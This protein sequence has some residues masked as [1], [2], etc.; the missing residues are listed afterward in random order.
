MANLRAVSDMEYYPTQPGV[1][2]FVA[3]LFDY[4]R[5]PDT[6]R[7]ID[8][9][10][11]EGDA[12]RI[13]EDSIRFE[14]EK[15]NGTRL[16]KDS[17]ETYG[18]E[19]DLN[20]AKEA[21]KK[22]GK[23]VQ[24]D[25][26]NMLIT[27]GVFNVNF[28]NP[29]YDHDPQ[30]KRLEQR[31]LVQ[32]TK[33]LCRGGIL[34]YLVPR[35]VLNVSAEYLSQNYS[36]FR[37]WQEENNYDAENFDQV[38]L[39][40]RRDYNPWDNVK[41]KQAI[42]DFAQGKLDFV[43]NDDNKYFIPHL[44][45]DVQRF[46]ALRIDYADVLSEI[47]R[48]G[49]ETR[50]EWQD[51]HLPPANTVKDPLMPP[52]VGHMG[53]IMSG[54]GVGGL[55]IALH[56]D[57]EQIIFRASSKKVTESVSQNEEGTV[58]RISERMSSNAVLLDPRNWEFTDDV[59]LGPFV[60]RWS[61]QLASYI[62]EVMP[63]KYTPEGLRELLGHA[64]EYYRLLR[65]PMPGNGQR[66]A[67]EG[68]MHSLMSGERG[69]TV[70]GEMGTGKTY[71][72]MAAAYLAGIRRVAVLCP[73]TLVW[74]WEKEILMTVPNARVYVVGKNPGGKKAKEPFY[75][76]YKSPMKQMRWL[77]AK[78]TH[79]DNDVPVY[80]ILAHSVAKASYGRIPA[81]H[82]RWGYKPQPLYSETTGELIEHSWRPFTVKVE[83][84][85]DPADLPPG[86]E[87]DGDHTKVVERHVQRICCPECGQPIMA[88]KEEYADWD[89]LCRGRRICRN[90]ITVGRLEVKDDYGREAFQT[91]T[92]ACGARLWQALAKNFVS[93]RHG[94]SP[95]GDEQ[96]K[97]RMKR[98]YIYASSVDAREAMEL[99]G[100]GSKSPHYE[101]SEWAAYQASRREVFKSNI[102]PPRR[103]DLAEYYKRYLPDLCELLIAD[104]FHQFKAGDSAQGQM[105]RMFAE[106]I[107]Q[108]ITLTGTLM[109]GYAR[110]LFHLLYGFGDRE[111]REDF[112]HRDSTRWRNQYG[113]VERTVYLESGN[114]KRSRTKKQDERPKDLPGAMPAV[115]RYILGHSVFIRLLDVA[116]G[117][118]EFSEHAVTVELDEEMDPATGFNQRDN[119]KVM[120]ERILREIKSLTFTNPKA[121]AKLVSIFAQAVLTYPDACTQEDACVVYSPADGRPLIERPALRA[122][123]LYP[124]EKKLVEIVQAEKAAGRKV[125]V[126][127]THTN[128]RDLLPRLHEIM[129]KHNLK[130]TVLRSETVDAD[131]RM[132]WLEEQLKEGL[133]V[134]IC[135]P[136][137]VETG[138]DMLDFPTIVWYEA[139]YNTARVR[140]ASRRSWRIGQTQ[141]VRIYYL[142]YQNTKQTQAIYLI[143]Q[144]VATSLAVE[145]DLSSDGLTALAGGGDNMGRS[146][147]Q[148]LVDS[149]IEF[150]GSFESGISIAALSADAEGEELLGDIDYD[151]ASMDE[152]ELPDGL[153]PDVAVS[154]VTETLIESNPETVTPSV[155]IP[156]KNSVIETVPDGI[157]M[158]LFGTL[159]D[160]SAALEVCDGCEQFILTDEQRIS[161]PAVEVIEGRN[162]NIADRSVPSRVFHTGC[163]GPWQQRMNKKAGVERI[164]APVNAPAQATEPEIA[165]PD[166][167]SFGAV[168]MDSWMS[169]FGLE[170]EDLERGKRKKTRKSRAAT[171]QPSLITLK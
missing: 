140:Q 142:T 170:V 131:K 51:M 40:A 167:A 65:K 161:T 126:F 59:A 99:G 133:D 159:V 132:P 93:E 124:K 94:N 84:D 19:L 39:M 17:I 3:S 165:P 67:I 96:L 156:N 87:P 31:F 26:S 139:D 60:S 37:I 135:H 85:V 12:L 169:A 41:A 122:D 34:I 25:F 66:L 28:L 44:N 73:P 64:P 110:D 21:R 134:L 57:S 162:G 149:D 10:A 101:P 91:E 6:V 147:A 24:T 145:G 154:L 118:P 157:D 81:V 58:Q 104:E 75:R 143:A 98:R 155:E 141:P 43:G 1:P 144:K 105:A 70:V 72:S 63:P 52:R 107:P 150:D 116:A 163:Y 18:V 55:G 27:D 83:E 46:A 79:F 160:G 61:Q 146:I 138:V 82:F 168:S 123:K 42:L 95:H 13:L 49:Y 71:I 77:D 74:K 111:I 128:R 9:S 136:Q 117:L 22:L 127:A 53:L 113:F 137:L 90:E 80:I 114:A 119:Y 151:V 130:T 45:E 33:L 109:A 108:S 32:S 152:P 14:Y 15:R 158:P 23:V 121:A 92:R 88:K 76:L 115:L 97:E 16:D 48:S 69:T 125:L 120:E 29:P 129:D 50:Q 7:M 8:T 11:G 153:T 54:G 78:Y 47:E 103:Y 30:Y 166:P 100:A 148:M 20:R 164:E 112:G 35:H 106:I 171:E 68:A 5:M 2:A 36:E 86:V 56:N 4:H 102:Y 89:W 62:S 38:I